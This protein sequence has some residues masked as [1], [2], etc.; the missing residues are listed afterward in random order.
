[1]F[2]DGKPICDDNWDLR[3]AQVVCGMLNFP[4]AVA[5]TRRSAFGQ[6][7]LPFGRNWVGCEGNETDIRDCWHRTDTS[8]NC[9][10][11]SAAGVVCLG[12]GT[13]L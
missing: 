5:A 12:G 6:V 4:G 3:D 11:G 8:F 1:M 9:D 2:V 13:G 7:R 10:G